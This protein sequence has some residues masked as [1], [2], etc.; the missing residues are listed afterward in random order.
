MS[1]LKEAHL[2]IVDDNQYDLDILGRMLTTKGCQVD[3]AVD[4]P[5]LL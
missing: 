5:P 4:G 1:K 2:L 3:K